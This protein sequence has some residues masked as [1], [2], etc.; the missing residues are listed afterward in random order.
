MYYEME[1][2]GVLGAPY[3]ASFTS[4]L[5]VYNHHMIANLSQ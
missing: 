3:T 4:S 1:G 2:M 5:Q